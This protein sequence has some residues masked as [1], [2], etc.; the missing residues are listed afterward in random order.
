MLLLGSLSVYIAKVKVER[1]W[2]VVTEHV[3][4][5]LTVIVI[6]HFLGEWIA[7]TFV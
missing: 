7:A 3:V 6:A 2:K 4:I 5:A 1:I